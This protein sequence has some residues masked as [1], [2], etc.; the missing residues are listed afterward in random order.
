MQRGDWDAA[1]RYLT[2]SIGLK[3]GQ[4]KSLVNR[5]NALVMLGEEASARRDYEAA[6]ANNP[7]AADAHFSLA[8]LAHSEWRLDEAVAGY[9]R[10]IYLRA[11]H[12][13]A[14][15]SV[16]SAYCDLGRFDQAK[17]LLRGRLEEDPTD[18]K[19]FVLLARVL[20]AEHSPA[21]AAELLRFVAAQ[22]P[23]STLLHQEIERLTTLT[24]A[25]S[26]SAKP[27]AAN[28]Q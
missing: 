24:A 26:S 22:R 19:Q 25:A 7:S 2:R 18:D 11:N 6:L 14:I 5:G 16:V 13:D 21:T 23:D 28:E 20:E 4:A 1:V 3:P 8:R 10:A 9:E 17:A 15:E 12:S 27:L